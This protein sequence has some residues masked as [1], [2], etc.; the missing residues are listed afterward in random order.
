MPFADVAVFTGHIV[1]LSI[2]QVYLCVCVRVS[3]CVHIRVSVCVR[4]CDLV[5]GMEDYQS[6]QYLTTPPQGTNFGHDI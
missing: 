1:A 3:V 5:Q 6:E 4:V 2:R